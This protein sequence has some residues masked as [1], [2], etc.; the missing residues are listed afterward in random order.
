VLTTGPVAYR[1]DGT[2]LRVVVEE[3]WRVVTVPRAVVVEEEER[4]VVVGSRTA[5][6]TRGRAGA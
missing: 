6:V 2:V 4:R 3:E 5:V 1:L